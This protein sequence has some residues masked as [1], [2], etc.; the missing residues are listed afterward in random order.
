[1]RR[2]GQFLRLLGLVIEFAG[3]IGVVRERGGQAIPMVRIPGGPVASA[4]WV[5]VGLGF[6]L[7]LV[8]TI[9]L[10]ANR[11]ARRSRP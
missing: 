4:A 1:M 7:W 10:A 5:A 3:V 11:P 2:T 6:V 9:L 8:G